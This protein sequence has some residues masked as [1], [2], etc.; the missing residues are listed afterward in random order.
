M[1]QIPV[2]AVIPLP[3][4]LSFEQA[5]GIGV[6][7]IT[8]WAALVNAAQI[9][10]GETALILGTTGA[11]GSAAARIARQAW[12]S[13]DWYRQKGCGYT[14]RP[15]PLPVDDWIDLAAVDLATGVR[16]ANQRARSRHRVR[17]GRWRHV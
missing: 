10:A 17:R 11:V 2:A 14:H 6:A 15:V 1:W 9:H 12:S 7:Y 3:K 13:R 16:S 8:A 5:A 4:N